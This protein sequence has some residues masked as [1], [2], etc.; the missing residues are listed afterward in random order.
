MR[1]N[2]IKLGQKVQ[3]KDYPHVEWE[4]EICTVVGMDIFE[5]PNMP[6]ITLKDRDGTDFDGFV[7]ENLWPVEQQHSPWE[8]EAKG[9]R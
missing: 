4:G 2:D 5:G 9:A 1:L 8:L 3:I 7:P 6:N